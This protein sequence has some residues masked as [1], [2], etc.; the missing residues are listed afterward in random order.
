[1]TETEHDNFTNFHLFLTFFGSGWRVGRKMFQLCSPNLFC[2][3]QRLGLNQKDISTKSNRFN[4]HTKCLRKI[5]RIS[6]NR[7]NNISGPIMLMVSSEIDTP[8]KIQN[9]GNINTDYICSSNESHGFATH[10]SPHR[11]SAWALRSRN[12][13]CHPLASRKTSVRISSLSVLQVHTAPLL[14]AVNVKQ[15]ST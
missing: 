5:H 7:R 9:H 13:G 10:H 12:S 1:M 15:Q 2:W 3:H 14:I 4:D 11:T 6:K 8:P